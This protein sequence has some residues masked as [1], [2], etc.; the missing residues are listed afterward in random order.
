MSST[1][2]VDRFTASGEPV[3]PQVASPRAWKR[4]LIPLAALAALLGAGLYGRYWWETGR[5]LETTDDAYVGGDVTVIA[6][7]VPGFVAAVAVGDNQRIRAGDLLLRIDDRD[8]RA[9]LARAEAAVAGQDAALA[10]LEATRALQRAVI[11][12]ARADLAASEAE[13]ARTAFDLTRYRQLSANQYA[14]EQRF[15]QAEADHKKA[16]AAVEKAHATLD[17]AE[18]QLAV[19]DTQTR[20][21]RAAR[22]QA[23]AEQDIAR[24]NLGYTEVRAPVDGVVGNRSARTGSYATVGAS[25][26]SLVPA[27]G[28]WV[29]AN[30]KESQLARMRPGQRVSVVADVLPDETFSGHVESLAPATGAQFSILPPENA[31]GNFT[32]IV[33]RV[34]VRIRLDGEGARLGKLRPGLSVTATVDRRGGTDAAEPADG[35]PG[36]ARMVIGEATR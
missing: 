14:S 26:V 20:Q 34:P 29:D 22:E 3:L 11:A 36:A 16:A 35:R 2:T 6:S 21:V 17:A 28:L 7:K 8:Y 5:F 33:Q 30:F 13:A 23:R 15:Q 4:R 10:N 19:I 12:Q 31:T 18:R 25:L 32:K 24:L 9:A 1:A 27:D